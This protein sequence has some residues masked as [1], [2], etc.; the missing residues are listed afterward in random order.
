L[1][2][3]YKKL[4][5]PYLRLETVEIQEGKGQ[6]ERQ[7][8]EESVRIRKA[9][10]GYQRQVLLDANGKQSKSEDFAEWLGQRLDTGEHIAFAI[11]SSQGFHD[12]VKTEVKEHISLGPM[13]FPHDLCRIIFLEQLYRALNIIRCGPYH[14]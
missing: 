1:E 9:L 10:V 6:S 5:K 8:L 4:I 12:S 2:K 13:T 11:G 3:H 14:K 7:L